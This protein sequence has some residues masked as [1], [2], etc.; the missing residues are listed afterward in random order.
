MSLLVHRGEQLTRWSGGR[1]LCAPEPTSVQTPEDALRLAVVINMP[2][3]AVEDTEAQFFGLLEQAANE[4]SVD[5]R[6]YSLPHIPR[7]ERT[8]EYLSKYY[9]PF[10]DLLSRRFDGAIVTGTEPKQPDLR[11][12]P[13]WEKLAALLDWAEQNTFS[14]VLSCLA[15]HAGVLYSDGIGRNPLGDKQFGVFE[16]RVMNGHALTKGAA[17]PMRIPHSRWNEVREETLCQNGYEILTKSGDAGVDLFVKQKRNSLFV[18]FQGHPEYGGHTLLKEYRRD[19]KRYL[20][21]ERENYPSVPRGYFDEAATQILADF[22]AQAEAQRYEGLI[23][24]FPE[25]SVAD[26]LQNSWRDSAVRVYQNWLD[27][28][29]ARRAGAPTSVATACAGHGP[30]D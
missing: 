17:N 15:A 28:V 10:E 11:Q 24:L 29:A 7:G 2:D 20:R 21:R 4:R 8:R 6:L 26:T 25:A 9:A 13:Y 19:V 27:Y 18:H 22:R 14:T 3:A 1:Y 23:E 16:H 5:V 30:R 12:E